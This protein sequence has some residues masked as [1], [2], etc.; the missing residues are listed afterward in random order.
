MYKLGVFKLEKKYID[1]MIIICKSPSYWANSSSTLGFLE[2][3]LIHF[4]P[5]V[6]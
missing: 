6:D 1:L 4:E 5:N 2:L 3:D